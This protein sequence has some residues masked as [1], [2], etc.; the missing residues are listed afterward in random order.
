MLEDSPVFSYINNLSPIKPVKSVHNTQTLD[1]LRFIPTPSVFTSPHVSCLKESRVLGRHNLLEAPKPKFSEYVNRTCSSEDAPRNSNNAYRDSS[2]LQENTDQVTSV[3]DTLIEPSSECTKFTMEL[4]RALT[5]DCGSPGFDPTSCGNETNSLLE[6][7]GE[8]ASDVACVHDAFEKD[9]AKCEVPGCDWESLMPDAA[10]MLIFNCPNELEAFKDQMLKSLDPT[11]QLSAFMSSLSQSTI[12]YGRQTHIVDPFA[13]GSEHDI[14]DHPSKPEAATDTDRMQDNLSD[15]AVMG[16]NL[17]ENMDNEHVSMT[18]RGTRRRCLNFEM[19][20]MQS[21]NLGGSSNTSSNICT[22]LSYERNV[23]S[24]RQLLPIKYNVDSQRCIFPGIGLHL[25]AL[26]NVRD[27][28]MSENEDFLFGRQPSFPNSA[29]SLH[30]LASQHHQISI[31]PASSERNLDP[32]HYEAQ[33]AEDYSQPSSSYIVGEGVSWIQLKKVKLASAGYGTLSPICLENWMAIPFRVCS[34][35]ECFAAGIYCTDPCSCTD[36]YNKPIHEETVLET[37]K[38]IESRNP[39]AFAPKVIRSADSLPEIGDDPNKTPAS[40][41]HKRGCNCKKSGCIKKYCECYQ[42]GVGCSISCRCEGCKNAYGRKDG[43]CFSTLG[44]EA[45][46]E[47]TESCEKRLAGKTVQKTEIQN[48]EDHADSAPPASPLRFCR[49]LVPLPFSSKG[50]PQRSFVTTTSAS[51]FYGSQNFE[52]PSILR[53]Q[54][55]LL[56]NFQNIPEDEIQMPDPITCSIKTRS[57]NSK[58]ISSPKCELGPSPTASRRTGR[59]L[60]LQSIPSFPSL[61]PNH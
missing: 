3:G 21:K 41:R 4:P 39:L 17:N 23:P 18:L 57:P 7:P 12:D 20:G 25:N 55:K 31:V 15:I 38:L 53:S 47:E 13:S 9:S 8:L 45:E 37:R 49:L 22:S 54:P 11:I 16:S 32:Q 40:A 59:K 1:S 19:A 61:N 35:C 26:A 46:P 52:K 27:Y 6:L 5:Y 2:E 42:G 56:Q 36:C 50:Q 60:I 28:K 14:E 43:P 29:S 58:R 24:H 48:N 34:Y 30:L 51:R 33:P 10:D 44:I